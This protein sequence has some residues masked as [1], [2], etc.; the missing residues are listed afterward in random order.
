MGNK[1][2]KYLF[3]AF[4]LIAALS[5]TVSCSL[6]KRVAYDESVLMENKVSFTNSSDKDKVGD[7]SKYIKQAPQKTFLGFNTKVAMYNISYRMGRP[8][9]IFDK[10]QVK[11]SKSNIKNHLDYL[12]YYNSTV[13]DKIVTENK[14]TVV[15]Y[16]INLGKSYQIDS[17]IYSAPDEN[18]LAILLASSQDGNLKRGNHLSESNLEQEVLRLEEIFQNKGYFNF[19]KNHFSFRADTIDRNGKALLYVDLKDY[20]LNQSPEDAQPHRVYTFGRPTVTTIRSFQGTRSYNYMEDTLLTARRDSLL[21]VWRE[22]NDT[23]SYGGI[24]IVTRGRLPV[25]KSS[26]LDRINLIKEGNRYN[27]KVVEDT[28][29]RFSQ[30]GLFSSVGIQSTPTDSLTVIPNITLQASTLQGYKAKLEG[31]VN[32]NG[33]LGI[34]PEISYYHK[35]LFRGAELFTFGINADFQFKPRSKVRSTE[36]GAIATLDLPKFLFAPSHWF[37]NRVLPH[38]E[39]NISYN[40]QNRPEYKRNIFSASYGYTWNIAQ[41]LFIKATPMQ[42]NMVRVFDLDPFFYYSNTD[43]FLRYSYKNHFDLGVGLNMYY[44][45]DNSA[46]PLKNYFY[47]RFQGDLAGNL[48]SLF[49]GSLKKNEHGERMILKSPYSQYFKVEGS[50]VYTFKFGDDP[51]H[52]LAVRALAGVGKGYHNSKMLPFEKLFWGGGA[53]SLRGWQARTLGPGSAP[54]DT[55]FTLPNQTGDIKLEGNVEYRF[56]MFW[57]MKGAVFVDAGNIW[58]F[59]REIEDSSGE[60]VKADPRGVFRFRDFYKKIALDWGLGLRCDIT[61]VVLRLDLGF[62]VHDPSRRGWISANKW[63]KSDNCQITFGIGYPF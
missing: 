37:K 8:P 15:D 5:F 46:N 59:D 56:P 54:R 57:L 9:V 60:Y 17:V 18:T 58:T 41:K 12:G 6:T 63:F 53:Y 52:M 28:Y 30:I 2:V 16:I 44:T 33:L 47:A 19:S 21:R 10:N 13:T 3:C 62:K 39:M 1:S 50:A 35:N 45:T 51:S 34:S 40:Y 22:Q 38:T 11:T 43:P 55:S 27:R 31:S 42:F 25:V 7:V 14:K 24:N 36:I 29:T 23:I 48:L 32:S 49:N 61:Y 4:I 26:F 20:T